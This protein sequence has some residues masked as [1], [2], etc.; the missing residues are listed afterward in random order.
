[1]KSSIDWVKQSRH[2]LEGIR[3]WVKRIYSRECA[4]WSS[5]EDSAPNTEGPGLIPDQGTRSYRSQLRV[6]MPQLRPGPAKYSFLKKN[7]F[8]IKEKEKQRVKKQKEEK[9]FRN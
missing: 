9:K 3:R 5:G 8:K 7:I 1:M 2:S 6:Y 4:W